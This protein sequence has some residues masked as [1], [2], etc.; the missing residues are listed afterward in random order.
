MKLHFIY[1][2]VLFYLLLSSNTVNS[3]L[4]LIALGTL[5][6]GGGL[7]AAGNY[8]FDRADKSVKKAEESGHKLIDHAGKVMKE[9]I[10]LLMEQK[11]K[12]LVENFEMTA[13]K[14]SENLK[15]TVEEV[16]LNA[17]RM[18]RELEELF[19]KSLE[20]FGDMIDG[21]VDKLILVADYTVE[22]LRQDVIDYGMDRLN[23]FKKEL[24]GDI[25]NILRVVEDLVLRA[26]CMLNSAAKRIDDSIVKFIPDPFPSDKCRK[27]LDGLF[28]NQNMML[29]Y[30]NTFTDSQ[31]YYYRNCD[32]KSKVNEN[33]TIQ[34]SFMIYTDLLKLAADMRCQAVSLSI[35]DLEI[36]YIEEMAKYSKFVRI[37]S[38]IGF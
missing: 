21:M 20:K 29:K 6:V 33:S 14:I 35:P 11:V 38:A 7:A 3:S 36:Y 25:R 34:A 22:R 9:S 8:L 19:N 27:E 13:I 5:A 26:S 37:L 31:L 17:E 4:T 16:R 30:P 23:T 12:P 28:P 32:L 1:L 24:M 10:E 2:I 18:Q 15:S